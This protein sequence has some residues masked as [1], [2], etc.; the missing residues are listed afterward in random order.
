MTIIPIE[1]EN[2][3]KDDMTMVD[4]VSVT[5]TQTGDCTEANEIIQSLTVSTRNNGV[6]RFIRIET[7]GWSISGP[8]DMAKILEEFKVR[9]G[10]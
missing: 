9:A 3:Y 1:H 10:L 8:E 5:Y 7:S 4:T 6:A 2:A